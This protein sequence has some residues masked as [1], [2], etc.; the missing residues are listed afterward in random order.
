MRRN[1]GSAIR[2]LLAVGLILALAAPAA[3]ATHSTKDLLSIG[4]TGG[5]GAVDVFFNFASAN[6]QR[7]F[8]ETP[9][10]LVAADTDGNYDLYQRE[11]GTT[12]LISTGPL[13]GN[14]GFDVFP[15]DTTP[16]G[17]RVYFETDEAL[18]AA[19]TDAFFDVYERVGSTTNLISIGPAGG[20]DAFDAFF[21]AVSA[22]GTRV[23]FDTDESLVAG[24][25]DAST[26]LYERSAGATTLV[27]AG[28]PGNA[29]VPALFAGMSEDGTR[30]FFETEES[31]A[32]AD[33]DV[34]YDVY[35]RASGATTLISTGTSAGNGPQ[36][37]TFRGASADGTRVFFQTDER[38]SASDT[39]SVSDVYE[40]S[41]GTTTL[42]S[43]LGN[44]AFAASWE[45]NSRDGSRV[46]F[47][48]RESLAAGD[49]D[50]SVDVYERSGGTTK[51]VT[52]GTPG[53]GA[54]DARFADSSA[55][56]T[57]VF[58]E[59]QEKL[60]AADTD[61]SFDV[62]ERSGGTTTTLLSTG[63]SGGNGAFDASYAGA[64]RDGS[65]VLIET[66]EKLTAGDTDNFN[67][68]YERYAGTTTHISIGTSGGNAAVAA[69]FDGVST[70]GMRVFFDTRE[71]LLPGDTDAARDLYA[72]DVAGYPRPKGATPI[73]VSLVPAYKQCT[74]SNRTHGPPL[75]H[76]AC[77]P[78]VLESGQL[79]IGSPDANGAAANSSG[80]AK[81]EA[82]VGAPG[83]ADDSD[84]AFTFSLTDVRRQG[85]L[86][87][88]TGQL[89][90]TTTVRVTD[91]LSGPSVTES[92]TGEV[93]FP[94]TVPCAAT[95]DTTIGS[96][97]SINTTLDAVTPG[98]VPEGK[99]AI[100]Q[101]DKVRVNDGGADGVVSTT[102][103]TLYMTQGVF[104]P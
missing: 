94:V 29:D 24:D 75:A 58:F 83:G 16:D 59:T 28:T 67:D 42:V 56:G 88:Y 40:R 11:H 17:S 104:I 64:A 97:C 95:G 44:G 51:L 49:T 31:L 66:A 85:T 57:R 77:N 34:L 18:V 7:A 96:T 60:T 12:T 50:S 81:Y 90:A 71:S 79:T 69:F 4:S 68:V 27:S 33:T 15:S 73:R 3:Q 22:D 21:H 6:G 23:I 53:N 19:D 48:T 80:V 26:D 13:G 38:F 43:A 9:E 82:I 62:Y 8:F 25:T 37:A 32:A 72:A 87:D 74:S 55:D 99:R 65:R 63:T 14:A 84:I 78:P 30:I 39:D 10:S 1:A 20:N 45:G 35:Q 36:D 103:N 102:P 98:A 52:A 92:A 101:L 100:W 86:A 70:D 91:K 76:P 93:A 41:G 2:L 47:E 5:N 46:F 61:A 54:F 89:Q